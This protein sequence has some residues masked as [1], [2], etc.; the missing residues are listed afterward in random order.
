MK[1]NGDD[2]KYEK[3][4]TSNNRGRGEEH[5]HLENDCWYRQNNEA[6]YCENNNSEKQILYT[7]LNA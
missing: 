1:K 2:N 7:G 6:N 5:T 3:E 4:E